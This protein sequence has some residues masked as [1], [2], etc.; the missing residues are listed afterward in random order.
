MTAG[1]VELEKTFPEIGEQFRQI[2]ARQVFGD[3]VVLPRGGFQVFAERVAVVLGLR[4]LQG[5]PGER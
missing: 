2:G 1:A 5:V 4:E 3:A